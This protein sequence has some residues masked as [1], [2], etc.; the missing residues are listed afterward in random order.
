MFLSGKPPV[1]KRVQCRV[2]FI[3]GCVRQKIQGVPM[4]IA[5][6]GHIFNLWCM[7]GA[8]KRS[9]AHQGTR[10]HILPVLLTPFLEI[11]VGGT[12]QRNRLF[13]W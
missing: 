5:K 13:L 1:K 9:I 7:C 11:P 2:E 4:L 8:Q 12:S 10:K 3:K 6:I